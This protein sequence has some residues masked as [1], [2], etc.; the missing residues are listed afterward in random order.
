MVPTSNLGS[1]HGHWYHDLHNKPHCYTGCEKHCFFCI[2]TAMIQWAIECH[3]MILLHPDLWTLEK[4]VEQS[5]S[6]TIHHHPS[7]P[8]NLLHVW[9]LNSHQDRCIAVLHARFCVPR[10]DGTLVLRPTAPGLCGHSDGFLWVSGPEIWLKERN[11]G[12]SRFF[13]TEVA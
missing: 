7:P 12:A 10:T 6:I 2:S 9:F 3:W 8:T 11:L 1:W 4:H 13:P 5:P